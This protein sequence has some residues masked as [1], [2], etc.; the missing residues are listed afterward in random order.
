MIS[1]VSI[2]D[3]KLSAFKDVTSKTSNNDYWLQKNGNLVTEIDY[4]VILDPR[5]AKKTHNL[6]IIGL[7]I[8]GTTILLAGTLFGIKKGPQGLV[9][10]IAKYRSILQKRVE[11][12]RIDNPNI[13]NIK[14]FD[15]YALKVL[16]ILSNKFE[17]INNFTTM[18][19][20]A[21]KELMNNRYTGRITGK[22]HSGI[23]KL[24]E[25]IGRNS[26]V[27]SYSKTK[28]SFMNAKGACDFV[29]KH[30][31]KG[32]P[33]EIVE[34]GGVKRSR[35]QWV[36]ILSD[37]ND[38]VIELYENG[39]GENALLGRYKS[40]KGL[41]NNMIDKFKDKGHY[42]F[43]DKKT[44]NSFV[45]DSSISSGRQKI[46]NIVKSARQTI[47]YSVA[48]MSSAVESDLFEVTRL[49]D[50]RDVKSLD[51][52][53]EIKKNLKSLAKTSDNENMLLLKDNISK[54]IRALKEQSV[55]FIDSKL[56]SESKSGFKA[57]L[58]Q[59][60][61]SL[62]NVLNK[63]EY[64]LSNYKPGELEEILAIYKK[65]LPDVEYKELE[66]LYKNA[67]KSLDKSAKLETEDFVSK[68][69][70]LSLGSAPTDI[71]TLLTSFLSLGYFL[72]TSD[73]KKERL[74]IL[75]K[76]GIPGLAGIGTSLY[77]GAKLFAGSKALL[78]GA[79][80]TLVTGKIC[81]YINNLIN[82]NDL[83]NSAT[84]I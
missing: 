6:K 32:D 30:L 16:D 60:R 84:E 52:V 69:R 59:N 18:K 63:V 28:N 31:L 7:S 17:V 65:L 36:K 75:V 53:N 37:K 34:I 47:S 33:H 12:A 79:A 38:K 5:E 71:L 83:G 22:L 70:D 23:T 39:F 49:I 43:W 61:T 29:Q 54:Q 56:I 2:T 8:A 81:S 74:S 3:N 67:V 9:N 26:V 40:I 80:S 4:K 73:N 27:K 66:G 15:T 13:P 1:S 42:W 35:L 45:A 46:N 50:F 44:L 77:C 11:K 51:L 25:R 24:F 57:Q 20:F 68:I 48:D 64:D 55:K 10:T 41:M 78:I 82:K 76:Y 14:T 58:E 19:D 62:S 72:G 21:F